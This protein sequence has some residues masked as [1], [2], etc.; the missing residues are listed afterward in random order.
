MFLVK[1]IV[2]LLSNLPIE[3]LRIFNW[4]FMYLRVLNASTNRNTLHLLPLR[5]DFH[6][7]QSVKT[8]KEKGPSV[9]Y[10]RE[11]EK[12]IGIKIP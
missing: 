11:R 1:D 3:C 6:I 5:W 12:Q 7:L 4:N 2:F 10:A 9:L 8:A